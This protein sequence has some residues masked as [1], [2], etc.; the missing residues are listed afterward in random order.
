MRISISFA[1]IPFVALAMF[2]ISS[3]AAAQMCGAGQQ[4]RPSAGMSSGGAM[5]G[6]TNQ[7]ADDPMADKKP[8]AANRAGMCPCCRNM[9]MMRGGM[10][11]MQHRDMPG[12]DMPRQ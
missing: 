8:E 10:G 6:M 12:M 5:C 2:A 7:A 1:A 9:A 3:P 4:A 11:G